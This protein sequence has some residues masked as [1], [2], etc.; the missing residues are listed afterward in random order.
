MLVLMLGVFFCKCDPKL[1]GTRIWQHLID[2]NSNIIAAA[3]GCQSF[4]GLVELHWKI[5]IH[6]ACTYLTK[7]QMPR[8]FWFYVVAHSGHIRMP[9]R[10]NL[11]ANWLLCFYWHMAWGMTNKLGFLFFWSATF[12]MSGT[13]MSLALT[14]NPILW[15]A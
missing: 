14:A 3:A 13:A 1:F 15:M 9:L 11:V 5:M 8:L 10:A 4:N 6:M 12:I 7:K 2:I